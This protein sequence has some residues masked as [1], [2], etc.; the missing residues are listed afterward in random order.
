MDKL[1]SRFILFFPLI[2]TDVSNLTV[3]QLPCKRYI[4]PQCHR[5]CDTIKAS[6]SVANK[7]KDNAK[8]ALTSSNTQLKI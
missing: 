4:R 2:Y 8:V 7:S 6:F 3:F 1:N 5:Q